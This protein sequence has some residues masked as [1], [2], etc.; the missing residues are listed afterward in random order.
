MKSYFKGRPPKGY[1]PSVPGMK[2][3]L[4]FSTAHDKEEYRRQRG[5]LEGGRLEVSYDEGEPQTVKGIDD[6]NKQ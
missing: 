4:D 5:D 1:K 6:G 3:F 2:G